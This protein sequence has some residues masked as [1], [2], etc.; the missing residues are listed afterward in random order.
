M[1]KC[2]HCPNLSNHW[3]HEC[4]RVP[5]QYS[6]EGSTKDDGEL[7][8]NFV[9]QRCGK[10][11]H[12]ARLCEAPA[13]VNKDEGDKYIGLNASQ[14][15]AAAPPTRPKMQALIDSGAHPTMLREQ[16]LFLPF[17]LPFPF[18][19]SPF[20]SLLPGFPYPRSLMPL[21]SSLPH[22]LPPSLHPRF[23]LAPQILAARISGR[24]QAERK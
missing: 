6:E 1:K 22:F 23:L 5:K 3:T 12:I 7:N 20:L 8:K 16:S 14:L 2:Y 18:L 4:K 11:G 10:K 17:S 24:E 19:H 21:P 15:S 13:P 9:C